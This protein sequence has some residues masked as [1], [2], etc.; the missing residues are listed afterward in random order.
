MEWEE[1][2]RRL[3]NGTS[4]AILAQLAGTTYK[5]MYNRIRR[6]EELDNCIY[7][8]PEQLKRPYKAQGGRKK[9]AEKIQADPEEKPEK[10]P[11]DNCTHN[12][13]D[14]CGLCVSAFGKGCKLYEHGED[15]LPAPEAI[16]KV[17]AQKLRVS[18]YTIQEI[19]E[20]ISTYRKR[21]EEARRAVAE[22]MRIRMILAEAPE[23]E[24]E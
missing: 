15:E 17:E 8:K 13:D 6:R 24:N 9:K 5:N 21:E 23:V 7:L 4:V 20:I 16:R 18:K 1:I 11:C 14:H 12:L 19:E 22:W 2:N 3:K 10:I